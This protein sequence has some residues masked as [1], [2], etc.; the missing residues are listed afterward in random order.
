[1]A[2]ETVD[3]LVQDDEVGPSPVD[4]VTVL[5]YDVTGT[6]LLTSGVTGAVTSGHIQFP[7]EGGTNSSV[8]YQLRFAITGGTIVTPQQIEVFSPETDAPTGVN[9]F[10]ITASLFT[11]PVATDARLCRASG[12]VY[13]PNGKPRKGIDIHFIPCFNPLV[14]DG[15]GVLGERIACRT[16]ATGFVQVDLYRTGY[17]MATV[18]SHENIQRQVLV[19]NRSSVN[20]NKL[21]FPIVEAVTFAPAGAWALTIGVELEIVPTVTVSDF[22]VLEGSGSEDTLYT[23]ADPTIASIVTRSDKIVLVGVAAGSTTLTVTRA[24]TSIVYIPDPGITGGSV[25]ITVS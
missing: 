25:A 12:Y 17:Y 5:V 23:V 13:G 14:V 1:M 19:P 11:L 4:G 6:T 15:I 8:L 3:I 16:D 9:N 7:L 24:D 10:E 2:I 21:L 20:I 22:R 18:E